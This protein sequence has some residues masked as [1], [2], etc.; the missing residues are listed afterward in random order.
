M[1]KLTSILVVAEGLDSGTKALEKTAILARHFGAGIE[2]LVG[3][4]RN[5]QGFANL[6][7]ARGYE[8][9][10]LC[11]VCRSGE[12]LNDVVLRHVF[13]RSPDLVVKAPAGAGDAGRGKVA[14]EDLELAGACPV[15]LVLMGARPW[16][17][18]LKIAAAVDIS[19]E[20]DSALA[21]S[22]IHTAGFLNLGC[23]GELDVLYSEREQRD[24]VLR[25]ARAVRLARLVREFHVGGERLR[26]LE[27][28]PENTLP[29]A[30]AAGEYDILMLG[31]ISHR[32]GLSAALHASVA[33]RL[34]SGFDGDVVLV[35]AS[36]SA[37]GRRESALPRVRAASARD[38]AI[39]RN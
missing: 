16:N 13:E 6:C 12:S 28:A 2:L 21:R 24:E 20:D 3:E 38:S 30:T 19:N 10:M 39:L 9:V 5:T 22:I 23:E 8:E 29:V 17:N 34:L 18:P 27:G 26:H 35:P 11:S 37:A 4:S 31:A 36:V 14:H 33:R 1:E 7:N 32:E 25:M 15:P